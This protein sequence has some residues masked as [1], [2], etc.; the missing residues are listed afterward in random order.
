[1]KYVFFILIT[2]FFSCTRTILVQ[3][4]ET[5]IIKETIKRDTLRDTKTLIIRDTVR[6]DV[7][8]TIKDTLIQEKVKLKYIMKTDTVYLK[9]RDTLILKG[10]DIIKCCYLPVED[11]TGVIKDLERDRNILSGII[12]LLL[13]FGISRELWKARN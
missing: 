8:K 3:G 11:K 2:V 5:T 7:T 12:L 6:L 9:N 13:A 1:M 4:K 10:D